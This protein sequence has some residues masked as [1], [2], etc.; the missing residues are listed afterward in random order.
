MANGKFDLGYHMEK[1]E[2]IDPHKLFHHLFAESGVEIPDSAVKRFWHHVRHV[3]PQECYVQ[4]PATDAHI[5]VAI[6]GDSAQ[7]SQA[8][9]KMV[10]IF[11]SFPLWMPYSIRCSKWCI[12]ALEEHKLY[13][14]HTLNKVMRRITW[15]LGLAF[16]GRDTDGAELALGRVFCLTEQK[17]DWLWHKT[18]MRYHSNWT[19]LDNVCYLCSAK[20][21]GPKDELFYN[22]WDDEP[23][24][25]VTNK[26]RF[27]STQYFIRN[28]CALTTH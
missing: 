26:Q 2:M 3:A 12:W 18:L 14:P 7:L 25:V 5:P 15:S 20:G 22:Y 19:R 6:Y 17:G 13:G 28:P 21:V 27:F 10:G 8:A 11:L 23:A 24:W 4:S 9:G 16:N 1:Q